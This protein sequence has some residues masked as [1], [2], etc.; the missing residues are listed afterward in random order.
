MVFILVS[1]QQPD[2]NFPKDISATDNSPMDRRRT[3]ISNRMRSV[4]SLY[5][6]L[7]YRTAAPDRNSEFPHGIFKYPRS[8][9]KNDYSS[10]V[11]GPL[12]DDS[13]LN[14]FATL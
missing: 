9:Y 1:G 7:C 5:I 12:N 10:L 6:H 4:M 14:R 13:T 3:D 8:F 11:I 2:G